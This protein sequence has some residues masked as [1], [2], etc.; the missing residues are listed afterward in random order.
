[1]IKGIIIW[2]L[3]AVLEILSAIGLCVIGEAIL[4]K[5]RG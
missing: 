4:N 5:F 3:L 1:M 2:A